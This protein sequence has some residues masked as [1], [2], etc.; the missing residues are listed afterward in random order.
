M[1]T[2]KDRYAKVIVKKIQ[3]NPET[4]APGEF[5]FSWEAQ[6]FV[7][8]SRSMVDLI[9]KQIRFTYQ[10]ASSAR[11]AGVNRCKMLGYKPLK[12]K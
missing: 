11:R 1:M 5:H 3:D 10:E 9:I 12:E 4:P 2:T 7:A 8:G 6:L